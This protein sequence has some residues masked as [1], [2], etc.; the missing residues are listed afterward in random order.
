MLCALVLHPEQNSEASS[1]HSAEGASILV[2]PAACVCCMLNAT[3]FTLSP[4][5][6]GEQAAAHNLAVILVLACVCVLRV[7]H[8]VVLKYKKTIINH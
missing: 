5:E 1:K 6:H 4:V 8:C 7:A 3:P 2:Y